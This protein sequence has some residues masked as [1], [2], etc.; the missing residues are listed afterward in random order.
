MMRHAAGVRITHWIHAAG[1]GALVVSGVAILLA[2]PRLYWGET[3]TLGMPALV[4]LPLPFVF[5]H[6]GWGRSLHFLGA[7]VALFAGVSY[8]AIAVQGDHFRRGFRDYSAARRLAY[9]GIVFAAAP[10]MFWTGLAMSPA[11]TSVLPATVVLL[12]GQQSART[13][14]F[15][16][17]SLVLVFSIGHVVMVYRTRQR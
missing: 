11:F 12:G 9:F 7:W 2:H 16:V 13:I 8:L 10:L 4:E 1:F 17:A 3:G 5:G 14:H 15:I 6:T